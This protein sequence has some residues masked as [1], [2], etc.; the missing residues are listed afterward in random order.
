MKEHL[1]ELGHS[2]KDV[3][4]GRTGVCVSISF[5]L[6]G[7]I[8]AFVQ[9]P[10]DKDNKIPEGFW[11]DLKRVLRLSKTHVQKPTDFSVIPG[12]TALP[13]FNSKS[14]P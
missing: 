11:V 12:G 4:T 14:K 5:D 13:A 8:Q 7:C 10:V 2:V 1:Q 6:S 3:V 9:P